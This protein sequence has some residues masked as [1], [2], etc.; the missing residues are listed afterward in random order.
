MK[1]NLDKFED[2]LVK[3]SNISGFLLNKKDI[4]KKIFY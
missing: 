4:K 2:K 1:K 3:T